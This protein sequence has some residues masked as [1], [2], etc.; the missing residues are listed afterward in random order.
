MNHD[1]RVLI[2]LT[3]IPYPGAIF[4]RTILFSSSKVE[5]SVRKIWEN[6]TFIF[7]Y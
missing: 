6:L 7:L 4:V 1:G 3:L 5:T 2:D